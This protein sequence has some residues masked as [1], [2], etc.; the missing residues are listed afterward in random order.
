MDRFEPKGL[1]RVLM[2]VI[3]I[4]MIMELLLTIAIIVTVIMMTHIRNN[5]ERGKM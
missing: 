2:I 1:T 4:M 3:M 5:M